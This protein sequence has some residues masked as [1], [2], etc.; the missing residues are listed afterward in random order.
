[1]SIIILP[2]AYIFPAFFPEISSLAM[3]FS[4]FPVTFI[5]AIA[6][7]VNS[8]EIRDALQEPIRLIFTAVRHALEE[9]PPELASDI[10]DRG[11]V[12][13]GGGSL[14][15]G[16]DDALKEETNLFIK[17][18]DNPIECVVKGAGTIV[19]NLEDYEEVLITGA[20]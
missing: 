20:E 17:V 6:I 18:A 8:S 7:K 2:V 13:T 5:I 3:F 12:M 10:V 19:E 9:T 4:F 1:M 16:L 14:L 15:R 11:I